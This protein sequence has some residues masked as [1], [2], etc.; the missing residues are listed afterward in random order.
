[1]EIAWV[2]KLIYR[3]CGKRRCDAQANNPGATYE[4]RRTDFAFASKVRQ[5][6]QATIHGIYGQ[7]VANLERGTCTLDYV[8]TVTAVTSTSMRS[9][10]EHWTIETRQTLSPFNLGI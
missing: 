2:S 7:V 4:K 6:A 5:I 8:D 10:T 9:C 1:M 3:G